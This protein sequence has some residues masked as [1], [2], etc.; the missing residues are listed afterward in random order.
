MYALNVN[1]TNFIDIRVKHYLK[2]VFLTCHNLR[3]L[4][5]NTKNYRQI[6]IEIWYSSYR[7]SG[8]ASNEALYMSRSV[9]NEQVAE[10]NGTLTIL[11]DFLFK[12]H[13][14]IT[15]QIGT[16]DSNLMAEMSIDSKLHPNI[17]RNFNRYPKNK[18][19]RHNAFHSLLTSARSQ[20]K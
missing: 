7:K 18:R 4:G 10:F 3:L 8:M 13:Q 5:K 12:L 20:F 16:G 11:D 6:W 17:V 9:L 14:D 2:T 19:D 15:C 1:E